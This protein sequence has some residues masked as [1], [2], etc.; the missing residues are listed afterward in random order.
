MARANR[1]H[2]P[3][4]VW[5]ITHRCHKKEFLLKFAKDRRRW[6]SWLF[7]A[8]KRFGLRILNYVVTSN[9]IHLL[10]VDSGPDVIPKSLQ[11]I[12]GRTAQ[13]FNQRKE[14]KGAFWEDRYHATAVERNEHLIRCLVYID[15]NMVRAGVVDH[16]SEWEMSGF[17][18]IQNP[19]ERYGVIDLP[20]LRNLCGFPD[21]EQ[22]SEQ[23]RQWVQEAIK[24]GKSQREGCWT[25]SI[26]VGG[27]GF[28]EETKARLGIKGT[29][30]RIE[31]QEAD[32]CVLREESEPYSAVFDHENRRLSPNNGHFWDVLLTD[33]AG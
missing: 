29:G 33:S 3:G 18:E 5:H 14:R 23:H 8:K 28:V 11:L 15:L 1:H 10:V 32:Q 19:P 6:H 9:H 13:E 31:E 4:Q 27:I 24:N 12:A 16:P 30:K 17:N 7:E 20:C 25:E 21:H 26:A 22:F 2:I